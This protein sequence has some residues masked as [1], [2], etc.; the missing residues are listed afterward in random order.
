MAIF[1]K[2][3]H[4]RAI[5]GPKILLNWLKLCVIWKH[6]K[7]SELNFSKVDVFGPPY[8]SAMSWEMFH[9]CQM[10]YCY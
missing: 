7:G 8:C 4:E 6:L 3:L 10:W 9:C 1:S 5:F 2:F